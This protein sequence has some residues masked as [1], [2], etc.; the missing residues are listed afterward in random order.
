MRD[1][2][3]TGMAGLQD[4]II[5]SMRDVRAGTLDADKAK[6]VNALAQTLINSARAEVEL[7]RVTNRTKSQFFQQEDAAQER[8][9]RSGGVVRQVD[10]G[11]WT[12]LVHHIKD[13]EE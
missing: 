4:L 10:N 12:G 1:T 9:T 2:D 5:Q 3:T 13:D 11:P 6:A 8:I 7:L